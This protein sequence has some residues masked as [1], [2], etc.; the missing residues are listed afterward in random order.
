MRFAQI[1]HEK[2]APERPNRSCRD[3]IA[4]SSAVIML[5]LPGRDAFAACLTVEPKSGKDRMRLGRLATRLPAHFTRRSHGDH[6]G[7]TRMPPV[8]CAWQSP[9]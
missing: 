2:P 1:A 5:S 4:E 3:T 9:A 8:L 6:T 7:Y